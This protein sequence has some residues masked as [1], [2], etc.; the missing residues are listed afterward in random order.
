[1]AKT[2]PKI[3]TE[4]IEVK[5]WKTQQSAYFRKIMRMTEASKTWPKT[6]KLEIKRDSYS[7]QSHAV[8]Y[9]FDVQSVEWKAVYSVPYPH[10]KTQEGIMYDK[11]VTANQFSTDAE[12]LLAGLTSI[13]F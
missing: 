11:D 12:A 8:A 4:L 7:N 2:T 9:V 3:T 13:L 10:M 1:M 6:V 5:T